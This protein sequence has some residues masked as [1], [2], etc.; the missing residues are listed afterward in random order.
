M[1]IFTIYKITNLCNQKVYIGYTSLTIQER[2]NLHTKDSKKGKKHKSHLHSAIAVYGKENF[3]IEEIY[4]SLDGNHTLEIME[5]YFINEYKAQG[6]ELY[7]IQEGGKGYKNKP[8]KKTVDV[9]DSE[10]NYVNTYFGIA[11]A[12]RFLGSKAPIVSMACKNAQNNKA[13]QV[14]GYFVC[15]NGDKPIKKD[16]EYLSNRNKIIKPF[17]GKKRPEQASM[18]RANNPNADANVYKFKHKTGIVFEGTRQD[19]H[20]A[21]PEHNLSSSELG[22]VIRGN[23][24]SHRGWSLI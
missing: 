15:F 17:L 19:L 24:K 8:N 4:Q 20:N 3:I 1:S 22:L 12:A 9:Y 5:P 11:E 10:L 13:S 6:F 18:M 14:K 21:F 7:N 23:Y 2:F 16:T